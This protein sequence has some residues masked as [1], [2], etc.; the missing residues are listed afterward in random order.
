MKRF[1]S[2]RS[3]MRPMN[4]NEVF[5]LRLNL[6]IVIVKAAIKGY[7]VGKDRKAAAVKTANMVHKLIQDLDISF[8]ELK[9]P[10]HFL[11]ERIKLLS[12]MATAIIREDYPLGVHRKEAVLDNIEIITECAFSKKNLKLFHEILKVA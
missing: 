9:T 4:E 6:L 8:L 1:G 3:Q 7:P 11:K 5:L 10:S 2:S 12:V